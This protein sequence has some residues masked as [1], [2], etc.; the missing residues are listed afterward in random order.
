MI[1][2]DAGIVGQTISG[3]HSIETVQEAPG[4]SHALL[5]PGVSDGAAN[6]LQLTSETPKVRPGSPLVAS[7][8]VLVDENFDLAM[9]PKPFL[10]LSAVDKHGM[11]GRSV[12]N[13]QSI[14]EH[15]VWQRLVAK[16]VVSKTAS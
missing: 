13:E 11:A 4:A 2:F 3:S 7:V 9:Q 5:L 16:L 12:V 1:V 15:N 10:L 14:S 8:W 6:K